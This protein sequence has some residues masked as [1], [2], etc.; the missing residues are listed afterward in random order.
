MKISKE[1]LTEVVTLLES[2]SDIADSANL[3]EDQLETLN[4]EELIPRS[5][6]AVRELW[7]ILNG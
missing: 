5:E 6:A 2:L 4:E 7:S 1:L 3:M